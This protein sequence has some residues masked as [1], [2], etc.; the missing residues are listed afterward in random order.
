MDQL[1]KSLEI[2]RG[3]SLNS[4]EEKY[5][6]LLLG[7]QYKLRLP[8]ALHSAGGLGIE[9][10]LIQ[11]IGTWLRTG[12][13]KK[14]FHSHQDSTA[15]AFEK[16][17]SSMYG[18]TALTLVDEITS[19]SGEKVPKGVALQGAKNTIESMRIGDYEKCFRSRYFGVPCIKTPTYDKEFHVPFYNG[20]HVI[21]SDA[22]YKQ[23]VKIVENKIG[24]RERK[25]TL[26]SMIDLQ[27]LSEL[28][29]ELFKNTHDHGREDTLGNFLLLNFRGILIQ[30]NDLTKDYFD[31]WC[32]ESPSIAQQN[33]R[34]NWDNNDKKNFVLDISIFDFGSGFFDLVKT[35]TGVE[36]NDEG[37]KVAILKCFEEGWSRFPKS[38]RGSGLTKVL[39]CINKYHGWLRVRTDNL[40]IEKTFVEGD[41]PFITENDIRV[42]ENKVVGTSIHVSLRINPV[43]IITGGENHV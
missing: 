8:S 34:K 9:V 29:W 15:N 22:F 5:K 7:Q 39:Q 2:K 19:K 16:I 36:I 12:E 4:L 28:L 31:S 33:L 26:K 21:D 11:L 10:A 43:E 32:G 30:Q 25:R 17:C 40:V 23:I 13:Y 3:E 24:E 27:D 6:G 1:Y 18:L 38:N 14:I 20:D 42:L 41:S 37:K 35:K